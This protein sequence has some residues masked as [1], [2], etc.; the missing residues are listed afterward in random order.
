MKL[1]SSYFKEMKIAARGFYFYIEVIVA[2]IILFILL[3]VVNENP[4]SKDYEFLFYDMPEEVFDAYYSDSI[5]NGTVKEVGNTTFEAKAISFDV[6]NKETEEV[7]S[8]DFDKQTYGFLTYDLYDRDTGEF[9][10]HLYITESEEAMIHMSYLEKKIGATIGYNDEH[11]FTYN[12]YIQ[13]F[14]TQRL[15]DLLYILHNE[16]EDELR[17]AIDN[18]QVRKLESIQVLNNRE[19]LVPVIVVLMGS[20]MGFFIIMAY[21]FLDKYEGVIRAFAVTPSPVWEYLLSKVMIIITT[22]I[23]SS[24]I[25]TIPVMGLQANYPLFY[26]YLIISTFA[27]SSLG[28]LVASYFDSISKAFGVLYSIMIALMIPALSYYIPSFDPVWLRFFPTYPLLQGFKE[29]ML[30]SCD[31]S[32]V[33]TYS[34]VFLVGGLLLFLLANTRFKKTLTV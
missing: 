24:S 33:L 25:I 11:K 5:E 20:L 6:T 9:Q 14:E 32:Y 15:K 30:E 19:T 28:L 3:V 23:I 12:Y 16:S 13:G 26:L 1:I 17:G 8:Y 34:G 10:K 29:I 18:Q 21:I 2:A 4:V 22:V 7:T 27:F 31:V